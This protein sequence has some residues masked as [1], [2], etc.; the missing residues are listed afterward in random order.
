MFTKSVEKTLKEVF[1]EFAPAYD[2]H[3]VEIGTDEDYVHFL[4]QS[5]LMM[6]PSRIVQVTKSI[7]AKEIFLRN[8]E[9]KKFLWGGQFW[10]KGYYINTVGLH[11]NEEQIK[12]YVQEQGKSYQ[13]I[14]RDQLTLF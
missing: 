1:L 8:P 13:Q 6:L 5:V 3:F 10:T 4:I 11:S 9:V 7:I 2:I 14:Y 12:K